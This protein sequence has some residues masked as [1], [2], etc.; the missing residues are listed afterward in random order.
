LIGYGSTADADHITKP[1]VEGQAY[2]ME[3]ALEEAGI[4]ADDIDYI[5][6][7]GTATAANDA[8]ETQAIKKVFGPHAYHIPVSSTKSM[9]GH[10]L[11]AAGAVELI[12]AVL[13][14]NNQTVPPTANLTVPDPECDLDYVPGKARTGLDLKAVM[15]NSFAFGGTNAVLIVRKHE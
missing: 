5:N 6:A 4:S 14:L 7:H 12:A 11:G 8:V 3:A 9:H 15:S 13:A 10:L 2:A 1:S